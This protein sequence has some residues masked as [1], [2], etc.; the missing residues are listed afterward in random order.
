MRNI[1]FTGQKMQFLNQMGG[2]LKRKGGLFYI[3]ENYDFR[4][5]TIKTTVRYY[6]M[7]TRTTKM[8]NME[9]TKCCQ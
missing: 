7:L 8:R 9:T 5:I 4:E 6:S 3:H 1:N 2:R